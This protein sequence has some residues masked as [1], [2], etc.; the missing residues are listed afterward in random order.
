MN[1]N[2]LAFDD[3]IDHSFVGNEPVCQANKEP[4]ED[5][6]PSTLI[7]KSMNDDEY[8]SLAY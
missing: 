4:Y 2:I 1:E 5:L 6:V 8:F 7:S 3:F